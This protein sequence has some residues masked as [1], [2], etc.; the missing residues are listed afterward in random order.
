DAFTAPH[1]RVLLKSRGD[2]GQ[3]YYELTHEAL[4]EHWPTLRGWLQT[5]EEDDRFRATLDQDAEQWEKESLQQQ[6][7]PAE[8]SK[9]EPEHLRRGQLWRKTGQWLARHNV[10]LA[11][12]TSDYVE[13]CRVFARVQRKRRVAIFLAAFM[14]L[15]LLLAGTW[16]WV[17]YSYSARLSIRK[18]VDHEGRPIP[19]H[20][21]SLYTGEVGSTGTELAKWRRWFLEPG[22]TY[23]VKVKAKGYWERDI[24][25]P[26]LGLGEKYGLEAKL[27]STNPADID[28][29]KMQLIES[30]CFTMGSSRDDQTAYSNEKP[31]HEVC[32]EKDFKIGSYEVTFEQYEWFTTA[33]YR[34]LPSDDGWGQGKQPVI[35]VDWGDA[36]DYAA[37]LSKQTGK[38]YRLPTEAEWEYAAKS[39]S[40]GHTWSGTPDESALGNYAWYNKNSNGQTHPVGEKLPNGFGLY[41]MSGNA[42]EWVQDCWHD[43]FED[44]GRPDDGAAWETGGD[45]GRR[46]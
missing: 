2:D 4:I 16:G 12:R 8:W 26:I 6:D 29:P 46:V 33:T 24:Q 41:D 17:G 31:A 5:E 44:K 9:L 10:P 18:V 34:D 28:L 43:S 30:G 39:G 42:W 45:C 15:A 37:W 27:L 25:L 3:T 11:S 22:I 14:A 21:I 7:K 40:K 13:R 32:V 1:A 23:W 36:R 20:D 19:G 35:N 38:P